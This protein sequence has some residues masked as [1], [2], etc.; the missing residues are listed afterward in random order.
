[1]D[2]K[3]KLEVF[4]GFWLLKKVQKK[5]A[6]VATSQNTFVIMQDK[7]LQFLTLQQYENE[8]LHACLNWFKTALNR[9]KMIGGKDILCNAAIKRVKW[10]DLYESIVDPND[11]AT[12]IQFLLEAYKAVCF[13]LGAHDKPFD[14]LK[15]DLA[16]VKASRRVEYP[17]TVQKSYEILM[18]TVEIENYCR[19]SKN[20]KGCGQGRYRDIQVSLA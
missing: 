18:Q 7:M 5:L 17:R 11:R 13:V 4:D 9:L 12:I 8:S 14:R 15:K 3:A 2:H 1:M 10:D 6:G 16:H 20:Y 19:N